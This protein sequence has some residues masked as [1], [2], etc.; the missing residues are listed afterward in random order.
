MGL[1]S[2]DPELTAAPNE[3]SGGLAAVAG[4]LLLLPERFLNPKGRVS[5]FADVLATGAAA[6]IVLGWVGCEVRGGWKDL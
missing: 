2:P 6:A 5:R 1:L 4:L 3:V